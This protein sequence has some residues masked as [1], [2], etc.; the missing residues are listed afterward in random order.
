[1]AFL[2]DEARSER[3]GDTILKPFGVSDRAEAGIQSPELSVFPL[4]VTHAGLVLLHPFLSRLFENTGIKDARQALLSSAMLPRAASLLHLLATGEE[5]VYEF[6]LGFIK[7]LLGLQ[8]GFALPVAGGLLRESDR[9]EADALLQAVLGHWTALKNTSAEALR[10]SFLQ[11]GGLVREEE[12]GF[13]LQ[14]EPESFDVL[15]GTLPWGI[16]T[17]KLPWMKQPIFTDWPTP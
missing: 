14:V 2:T 12:Q 17:V 1:M 13:R 5:E 6:E 3:S 15:L 9:E 11:R 16:G 7:I 4:A 10:L 8:P